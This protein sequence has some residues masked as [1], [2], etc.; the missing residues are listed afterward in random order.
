MDP[1][2]YNLFEPLSE[3]RSDVA[4]EDVVA[5]KKSVKVPVAEGN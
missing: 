2:T 5:L 3:K 1:D 4:E